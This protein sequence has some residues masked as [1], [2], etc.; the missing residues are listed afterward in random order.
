LPGD[1]DG[2]T[3][4]LE[5]PQ[6]RRLEAK[7]GNG[8]VLKGKFGEQAIEASAY[9]TCA[10]EGE[11]G[12]DITGRW[13]LDRQGGTL[14]IVRKGEDTWA[15]LEGGAAARGTHVGR[16][17][18]LQFTLAHFDGAHASLIELEPQK[19][20]ALEVRV[21]LPGRAAEKYRATAAAGR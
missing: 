9:C 17:D 10:Y 11:A 4:R 20:G 8:G 2:E 12:P 19:D 21:K 14:T 16:F 6:S 5:F 7:L 3:L 1:W 13:Q 15:K 18:G